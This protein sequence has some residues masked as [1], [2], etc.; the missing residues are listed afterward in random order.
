MGE[1]KYNDIEYTDFIPGSR[2][3]SESAIKMGTSGETGHWNPRL[4]QVGFA[5]QL[6]DLKILMRMA[7]FMSRAW[8]EA[9]ACKPASLWV[10]GP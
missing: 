10:E 5:L 4:D 1:G 7:S 8:E 9:R 3:G 2:T 6:R